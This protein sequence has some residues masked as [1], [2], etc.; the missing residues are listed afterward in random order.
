MDKSA[1]ASNLVLLSLYSLAMP[2]H[3]WV[4]YSIEGNGKLYFSSREMYSSKHLYTKVYLQN[5]SGF[6]LFSSATD[7]LSRKKDAI[8]TRHIQWKLG[9][10]MHWPSK[11]SSMDTAQL[12]KLQLHRTHGWYRK[13]QPTCNGRREVQKWHIRLLFTR[14]EQI[15]TRQDD[16]YTWWHTMETAQEEPDQR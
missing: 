2:P 9:F 15:K 8:S 13:W 1:M 14:Q 6:V 5:H 10:H 3:Y 7:I 16:T 4:F 11:N 12:A